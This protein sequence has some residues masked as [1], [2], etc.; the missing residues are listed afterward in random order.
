MDAIVLVRLAG[1]WAEELV[2]AE[3]SGARASTQGFE[4][5]F[6][7]PP[8]GTSPGRRTALCVRLAPPVWAW[9]AP[10]AAGRGAPWAHRPAFAAI[11]SAV[12][13][14][15]GDR[16]VVVALAAGRVHVELWPPG[17]IVVEDADGRVTWCANPRPASS[18][19]EALA[20][21]R[22]YA[23]PSAPV[24]RDLLALSEADLAA[25]F[26]TAPADA[27]ER[28]AR[29]AREFA[30]LPKGLLEAL[31]PTLPRRVLAP[32]APGADNAA[33][34]AREMR[35]WMAA[36]YAAE[37]PVRAYAWTWPSPGATLVTR[38]MAMAPGATV[39]FVG[40][41]GAWG[42]AARET[43]LALPAPVDLARVAAAKAALKR[44]ERAHAAVTDSIAEA[45]RA[46]EVRADATALAAF[47]PRVERGAATVTLPDPTDPARTRTIAL[48]PSLKPHENVDRLFKRAA[49][50]ERVAA[51]APARLAE[52]AVQI[53]RAR[54]E[55]GAAERGEA[56]A[57]RAPGLRGREAAPAP[58]R[59][60]RDET[61]S[62][63]IPRKFKTREGWE[64]W[65]GKNNAGNDHLTH[66]LARSEDVWMHVHGAAG[67][68]VVLRRG[69][70]PN[71]PS[72]ATLEEVAGWAA[73]Y[74][75]ARNAGTVPV[76]VTQKKYVSKPRKAPAGLA[77]VLRSK[78]V[79]AR[80]TE[81]PEEARVDAGDA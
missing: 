42:E 44:L 27:G 81:P 55:L 48:D 26:A 46:A 34:L 22:P 37:P 80:P 9:T 66:R 73:F 65:I 7:R 14:P 28:L 20:A 63:L 74:S 38:A 23:P 62:A 78:T 57:P 17:N 40:S 10:V 11:V 61:P 18:F 60:T 30:G 43:A 8:A 24:A 5:V 52:L 50:L 47:L 6:D 69:K 67:S 45:A 59:R 36:T 2:G 79:F 58:P 71:E 70:G 39:R 56:S 12:S 16:R 25:W 3:W 19:R 31:A 21:G 32:D 53:A 64:V 68:H 35:A 75:Q 29:M 54:A 51:Q 77:H 15:P 1:A 72:K 33:S 41:Y 13:T 4:L 76:T 49:K